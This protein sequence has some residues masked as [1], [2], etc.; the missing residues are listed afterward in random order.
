MIKK[1]FYV[2]FLIF[3]VLSNT[4]LAQ[5]ASAQ[6]RFMQ[7]S[8]VPQS[9][10]VD[11]QF[12]E[13]TIFEDI[14]FPFATDYVEVAVG[15]HM[16]TTRIVDINDAMA[17]TNFTL[18][19]GHRYTVIVEGDYSADTVSFI[20]IDETVL[21]PENTTSGAIVAN[22]AT[23]AL[24]IVINDEVIIADMGR[25]E[26]AYVPLP[27]SEF[28]GA[29]TLAGTEEIVF[30]DDFVPLPN[31][32]MLGVLRQDT[33]GGWQPIFHRWSELSIAEFLQD[34]ADNADFSVV[35]GLLVETNVAAS[36]VDSEAYTL[37]LPTNNVLSDLPDSAIPS[38]NELLATLLSQHIVS[39]NLP[40][41]V[42]PQNEI[43]T[44]LAGEPLTLNFG[45]TDS[46]YWEIDGAPILW[47]IRLA[48]GVIYAIS[49]IIVS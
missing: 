25:G 43:L 48:N 24:D 3:F 6:L 29:V 16:L 12:D 7:L 36:L 32:M 19:S 11:V 26:S 17:S 34:A 42:L 46:G 9:A 23:D 28:V 41:T 2:C 5:E 21:I 40:P 27:E 13:A 8:F 47:D 14:S 49:G 38:D 1:F 33:S 18:E 15:G 39:E 10:T 35:A 20:L 31:V 4:D 44:S 22:F 37:F 30:S 45:Q